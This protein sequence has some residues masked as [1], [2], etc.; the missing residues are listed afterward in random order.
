MAKLIKKSKC[1]F[2]NGHIVKKNELIGIPSN[3][4]LQL[5]K[6]EVMVQQHGY[7]IAQDAY[8]PGPSLDGFVRRSALKGNRPYLEAPETPVTDKRVTEAMA[9]MKEVDAVNDVHLIN[10]TIDRFGELIDWLDADKFVEGTCTHPIDTP[11]L[12]NPLELRG[13]D[14]AKVIEMLVTCPIEFEC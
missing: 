12:G 11:E 13:E 1:E 14:I 7:I 3:V 2:I 4:W 6:L 10:E 8:C 5:N 9:F